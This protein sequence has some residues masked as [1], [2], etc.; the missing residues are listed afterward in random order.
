MDVYIV[1]ILCVKSFK[2]M[3]SYCLENFVP[4]FHLTLSYDYYLITC[5][6][7]SYK[8]LHYSPS[9]GRTTVYEPSII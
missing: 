7:E 4:C 1:S 8:W 9:Y 6:P 3:G 2:K 5:T